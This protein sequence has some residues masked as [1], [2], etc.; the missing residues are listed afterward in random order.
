M[1]PREAVAL[2]LASKKF[3]IKRRHDESL[4]GAVDVIYIKTRARRFSIVCSCGWSERDL[5]IQ[6]HK[7]REDAQRHRSAYHGNHATIYERGRWYVDA[8]PLGE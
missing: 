3:R 6:P 8:F 2:A 4:D 7:A 1:N 5:K